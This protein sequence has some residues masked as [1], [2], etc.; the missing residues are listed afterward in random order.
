MHGPLID[1]WGTHGTQASASEAWAASVSGTHGPW[2][3]EA[4][5]AGRNPGLVQVV[6]AELCRQT[7]SS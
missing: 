3:G 1:V 6:R 4:P 2:A 5:L 7:S